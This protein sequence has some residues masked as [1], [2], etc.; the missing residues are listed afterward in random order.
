MSTMG[1][2]SLLDGRFN[3]RWSADYVRLIVMYIM[4]DNIRRIAGA[5]WGALELSW[6]QVRRKYV[7]LIG[8][9][10]AAAASMSG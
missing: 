10:Q 2:V 3:E 8:R 7:R 9:G 4:S 1:E 5:A 6:E